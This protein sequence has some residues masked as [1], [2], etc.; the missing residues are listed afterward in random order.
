[1]TDLTREQITELLDGATPG[2]WLY[3]PHEH[4]DWGV[5]RGGVLNEE[6]G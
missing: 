3:R 2:P 6:W 1:M 5:V 4:D